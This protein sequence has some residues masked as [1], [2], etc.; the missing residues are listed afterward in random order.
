MDF[1]EVRCILARRLA[2]GLV[3]KSAV[4]DI[5]FRWSYVLDDDF[6]VFFAE[7][8]HVSDNFSND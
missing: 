4:V 5:P 7:E 1:Q 6:G 3:V 2:E 8:A